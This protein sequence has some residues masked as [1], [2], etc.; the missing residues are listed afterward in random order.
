[1]AARRRK[2]TRAVA[3][4]FYTP[5]DL[6]FQTEEKFGSGSVSISTVSP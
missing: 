5:K 6:T 2:M 4:N 3:T 1:V